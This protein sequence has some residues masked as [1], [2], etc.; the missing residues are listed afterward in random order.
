MLGRLLL[1]AG[2]TKRPP[3]GSAGAGGPRNDFSR[4][5]GI[6]VDMGGPR[7]DDMDADVAPAAAAAAAVAL[8]VALD[9]LML[10]LLLLADDEDLGGPR[11]G[12]MPLLEGISFFIGCPG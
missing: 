3:L 12:A 10:L 7:G 4:P 8:F 5:F 11:G 1:A 9:E 2:G 6:C